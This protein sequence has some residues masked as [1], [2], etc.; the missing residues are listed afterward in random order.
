[1]TETHTLTIWVDA[2]SLPRDIQPLL[3][4]RA[5]AQTSHEGVA[6]L[7]QFIANKP[8]PQ[9]PKELI[10]IVEPIQGSAD[11]YIEAHA[12][13]YDIAVTRDIP[14]AERLVARSVY[15]LNDRGFEFT[16][17]TVSERRSLRDAA[18][19]LR[20]SGLVLP[21]PRA[22]LRTPRHTKQFADALDRLITKAARCKKSI[23][24]ASASRS[25]LPGFRSS[26]PH[27]VPHA[28]ARNPQA[29]FS[30]MRH[31]EGRYFEE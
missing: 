22:S 26:M 12:A 24:N 3:V 4:K 25:L 21:S 30:G 1:M 19:A 29:R 28:L 2:D 8:P 5:Q 7:V 14:L 16:R 11:R 27:F 10:T 15:V 23:G 9:L 31:L 13:P 18:A 6:I 17:E 20:E